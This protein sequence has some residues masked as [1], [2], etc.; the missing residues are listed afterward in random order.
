MKQRAMFVLFTLLLLVAASAIFAADKPQ[1]ACPVCGGDI[2]IAKSPHLD[3]QGQRIYFCCEHCMAKFKA[4]PEAS[5]AKS[6]K[7][8]IVFQSVQKECPLSGEDVDK[9]V[10]ADYKGR[11]VYF[12][13]T[14]C[15]AKFEKDPE[16]YLAKLPGDQPA[17]AAAPAAK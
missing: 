12:C 10:Y 13:C 11:R 16:K 15:K 17:P 3:W 5:F 9:K 7:E 2:D 14:K 4:D 1:T 6:A 8:G